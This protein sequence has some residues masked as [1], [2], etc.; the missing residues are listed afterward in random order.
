MYIHQGM[1]QILNSS[2]IYC[3]IEIIISAKD[4]NFMLLDCP[5]EFAFG[6]KHGV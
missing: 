1:G 2:R 4:I 3:S 5:C 6:N